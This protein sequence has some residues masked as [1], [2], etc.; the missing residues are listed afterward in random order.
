M[1]NKKTVKRIPEPG[2]W[3]RKHLAG[4][5]SRFYED[6]EMR[7]FVDEC[8]ECMSFD[9]IHD[10]CRERFGAGR[11]PSHSAIQRYWARFRKNAVD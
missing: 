6:V 9:Q 11:A 1:A 2:E 7:L 10:A 8:F 3:R 5:S 4:S